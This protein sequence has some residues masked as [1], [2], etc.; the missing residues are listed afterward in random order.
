MS[1]QKTATI[2]APDQNSKRSRRR[3]VRGFKGLEASSRK[4]RRALRRQSQ[5][6]LVY[7]TMLKPGDKK[8]GGYAQWSH[9][10]GGS[11]RYW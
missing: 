8:E 1:K 5:S 9:T 11:L 7:G 10:A 4:H 3:K 2:A 6:C